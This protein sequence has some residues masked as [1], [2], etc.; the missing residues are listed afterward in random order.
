M[1]S[2]VHAIFR[3]LQDHV[4]STLR[5]FPDLAPSQLRTGLVE[6]HTKLSNYY[7]HSDKSPYYTWA[8]CEYKFSVLYYES[9]CLSLF[10]LVLDSRIMYKGL[11]LDCVSDSL[12]L[13]DL[14]AAKSKLKTFYQQNYVRRSQS[15]NLQPTPSSSSVVSLNSSH[16]VSGSPE[17]VNFISRYQMKDRV[18]VDEVNEY[19]KLP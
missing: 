7:F 9:Q 12:L 5:E 14:D 19:F 13:A 11:K 15:T 2:T 8:A 17:K 16:G 4:S 3:G 10:L 1:L 18:M 6:A